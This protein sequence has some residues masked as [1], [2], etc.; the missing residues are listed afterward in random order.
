MKLRMLGKWALALAVAGLLIWYGR[1]SWHLLAPPPRPIPTVA[2]ER[3]TVVITV[4]AGGD[5]EGGQSERLTAPMIGGGDLHLTWLLPA[6][7]QV[8]PGDVVARFDTTTQEYNLVQAQE[9]L[10]E[11]GQQ[12]VQARAQ[13][14]AQEEE[15]RY[16]LIQAKDAVQ[17]AALEVRRDPLLSAIDARKNELALEAAKDNLTQLEHDLASQQASNR[18]SVVLQQ[19]AEQKARMTAQ[20]AQKNIDGMTLRARTGGYVGI[21]QNTTTN[22]A[23]NGMVLPAFQV[24]D[25]VNPGMAVAEIPDTKNWTIRAQIGELDRG[26]LAPGQKAEISFAGIPGQV[27][28]GHVQFLGGAVGPPWNRH[29]D[30]TL[31]LDSAPP[32]LRAGMQ[33]IARITTDRLKNVLWLPAQAVFGQNGHNLV[34]VRSGAAFVPQTVKVVRNSESKVVIEGLQPGQQV[35]LTNPT[36]TAGKNGAPHSAMEG[37]AQ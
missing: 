36:E 8:N 19:A 11:A 10:A 17:L 15:N 28:A 31:V 24:G 16:A 9:D 30:C 6:G 3:G 5:V 1:R 34:Y 23:F 29:S 37:L 26:H 21:E 14:A 12:V 4:R 20:T 18:A 33:A 13:S 25:Q 32:S 2:V 27:Y 22:F 35:A 7:T